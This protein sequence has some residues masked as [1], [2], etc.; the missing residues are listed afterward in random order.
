MRRLSHAITGWTY[1]WADD[2]VGPV[3]V[4]DLNGAQGRFDRNGRPVDGALAW[5]DPEMCRWIA[6]GGPTPGGAAANSRRFAIPTE[7]AEQP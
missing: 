6:S 3:L 5:A 4:T 1:E 2:G 7:S